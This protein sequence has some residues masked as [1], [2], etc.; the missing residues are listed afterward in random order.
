V[1]AGDAGMRSLAGLRDWLDARGEPFE[2]LD[3]SAMEAVT[4]TPFYR[5]GVRLPGSVLVQAGALVR[6]LAAALPPSVELF[7]ESPVR[8]ITGDGPYRLEAGQGSLVAGRVVLALNGYSAGLGVLTSRVFP[9]LT[10]G[11]LTRPLTAAEAQRLG[12]ER[13]WGVLAQ[14]PMGSSVRR[15]RDQRLLIRNYAWYG[16]AGERR[17]R[18]A[19]ELHRRAF[20]RRFPELG[21]VDFDSTWEGLL[22]I[23]SNH[24]PF[25]GRLGRDLVAT[26]GFTGAGIAMGTVAGRLLADLLLGAESELLDDLRALP[27]PRWIPPE[28]FRS[29]GIRA[30]VA[31]MNAGAGGTL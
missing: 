6:G 7:E 8:A 21:Q 31:R 22:G 11:S 14:D 5:A 2:W 20:L 30:R 4:G 19:R 28:P 24:Y 16:Q 25:F 29:L 10:F 12:G 17:L 26:A 18:V 15:T 13:E 9:L 27:G 3:G 23:S 1:A